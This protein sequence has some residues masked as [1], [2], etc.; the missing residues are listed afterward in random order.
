[1]G[2]RHAQRVGGNIPEDGADGHFVM[3]VRRQHVACQLEAPLH[4]FVRALPLPVLVLDAAHVVVPGP[5]EGGEQPVPG[6]LTQS[7][8]AGDLPAD[9]G[10][11]DAVL[12]QPVL[13]DLQVLGVEV[14]EAVAELIHRRLD[15]DHLPD[16][17]RRVEVE[18]D[19]LSELLEH[20]A[21]H[22]R[23]VGQVVP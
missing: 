2:V 1:M 9:P 11:E 23:R 5:V 4:Q 6:N 20:G 16:E 15:V 10:G 13:V 14:V 21:P 12:V 19:R 8:E 22:A 3:D 7:G 18:P 17:V